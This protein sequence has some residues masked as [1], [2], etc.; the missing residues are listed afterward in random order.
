MYVA[1]VLDDFL[2]TPTTHDCGGVIAGSVAF[3]A[4]EL[5]NEF[6]RLTVECFSYR[7]YTNAGGGDGPQSKHHALDSGPV[8]RTCIA[9]WSTMKSQLVLAPS[10]SSER[11][12]R[13]SECSLPT[14][15]RGSFGSGRARCCAAEERAGLQCGSPGT[16]SR[17]VARILCQRNCS[18]SSESLHVV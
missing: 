17:T 18:V 16:G 4:L 9:G 3:A 7:Q 13:G 12:G 14:V 6:C 11:P 2:T 5:P 10:G 15:G 1:L 8:A